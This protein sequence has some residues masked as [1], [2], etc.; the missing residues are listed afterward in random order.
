MSRRRKVHPL[1]LVLIILIVIVLC[2][3]G[4]FALKLYLNNKPVE[5]DKTNNTEIESSSNEETK[6]SIEEISS[7]IIQLGYEIINT[8]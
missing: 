3:I 4:F 2:F 7:V 1:R 6:I 5:E 8:K